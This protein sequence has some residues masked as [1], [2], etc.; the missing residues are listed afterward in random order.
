MPDLT[1]KVLIAAGGTGGHVFP[2]LAVANELRKNSIDVEWIGTHKGLESKVVPENKIPFNV[3]KVKGV[4]GASLLQKIRSVFLLFSATATTVRL[5]KRKNIV[6][7]LGM[8]GFVSVAAGIAA[9]ISRKPLILQEQNAIA[10]TANKVLARFAKKIFVAFPGVFA[11]KSNVV[12]SGN[13]LRS[14]FMEIKKEAKGDKHIFNLLVVGG[15]LGAKALNDVVPA[16]IKLINKDVYSSGLFVLHQ[17]GE[18]DVNSVKKVYAEITNDQF[19]CEVIDFI[20]DIASIYAKADL[21]IA[22]AGALTVSEIS[23]VGLPAVFIPYPYAID[24]HQYHNAQHLVAVGAAECI[25]ESQLNIEALTDKLVELLSDRE[26]LTEKSAQSRSW[27]KVEATKI[28]ADC[29]AE[30]VYAG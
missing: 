12:E 3:I 16:A 19:H 10:G 2:G 5:I 29:C 27:A 26:K 28:I 4:R 6:C 9:V 24:N 30:Y 22:R 14:E 13:P 15:S 11:G 18:R 17:T 1:N 25:E 21:I 23:A 7:V 8:G 20:D